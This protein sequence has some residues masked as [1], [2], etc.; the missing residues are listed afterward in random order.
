MGIMARSRALSELRA[1][2]G[3][4]GSIGVA[5]LRLR[6][7]HGLYRALLH[8][9]G[10]LDAARAAAGVVGP[11]P[12]NQHW[13]QA[14]VVVGLRRAHRAGVRL[15]VR[16][17]AAAGYR[18]LVNA[19]RIYC[20][21]LLRARK[22]ARLPEPAPIIYER[23]AWDEDTV[24]AEIKALGRARR[25]LAASKVPSKLLN[26][27][28]RRFGSWQTALEVAGFDYHRERLVRVPYERREL[29]EMLRTLAI[30][31]PA[32][33][34]ADLHDHSAA[35]AWRREFGSI[36]AAARIAGLDDWPSRKLRPL[37]SPDEVLAAIGVRHRRRRRL[38][39]AAVEEG[40]LRLHRS[41]A[42]HFGGWNEALVAAGLPAKAV[43]RGVGA[44]RKWSRSIVREALRA[45]RRAGKSMNPSALRA[46]NPGLYEA[47]K[48]HLGYDAEVAIRDWGAS[49]LVT[50]WTESEVLDALRKSHRLGQPLRAALRLAAANLFGSVPAAREAAGLPLLRTRWSDR[51]V[52]DEIRAL[53]GAKPSRT[54]VSTAQQRF[55]SWRA[56]LAAAGVPAKVRARWEIPEIV[57]A[58]ETRRRA[59]QGL[60]ARTLR[61]EDQSLFD[62]LRNRFGNADRALQHFVRTGRLPQARRR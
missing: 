58:L 27:A 56:A 38:N 46:D 41:A 54:L 12:K 13:S 2:A 9:F 45:R 48:Q 49:R 37:L 39:S 60:D 6:A 34:L 19:A 16:G 22:L 17:L 10:T 25:P 35:E 40:D 28:R 4:L 42:R 44:R 7:S 20:G 62:A 31:S 30:R 8:H 14:K 32:M 50:T 53:G 11:T 29:L 59:R 5:N 33:T 43:A 51:R 47:A 23:I 18:S 24:I 52:V 3:E 61:H 21:N 26:A 36:E 57:T 1:A 55:G 15:T